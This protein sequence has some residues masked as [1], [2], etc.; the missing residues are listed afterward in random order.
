MSEPEARATAGELLAALKRRHRPGEALVLPQVRNTTGYQYTVR[1]ADAISMGL[2]PSRGLEL[3]GF[4]IKVNRGDWLRELKDPAKAEAFGALDRWWIVAPKDMVKLDELPKGW[5]LLEWNG[6]SLRLK[7]KAE[8]RVTPPTLERGF[9]AAMLVRAVESVSKP[10][11]AELLAKH[12]QGVAEGLERS[13][14]RDLAKE[15]L[16]AGELSRLRKRVEEFEAA[17]GIKISYG[18]DLGKVGRIVAHLRDGHFGRP[19]VAAAT[20]TA[21]TA[22]ADFL[23]AIEVAEGVPPRSPGVD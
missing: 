2:W 6:A 5:G 17:S 1:Y 10:T 20:R 7:R 14:K 19:A 4:E 23:K 16:L 13:G 8:L 9:V 11:D 22:L 18:W 3:H 15:N 21:Q 12:Q